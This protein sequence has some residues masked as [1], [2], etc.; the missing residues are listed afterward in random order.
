MHLFLYCYIISF[1]LGIILLKIGD[2]MK[3]IVKN[4]AK[5]FLKTIIINVMC[6]FVVLSFSVLTTA[7]FTHNIGYK[8]VGTT[9]DNQSQVELYTHYTADGEDTKKAEYEAK[10]YTVNELSIRSEVTK[11]GNAVFLIVSQIFCALILIAFIYPNIWHIGTTDSNLVKFKH[12]P[13][14]KLKGFKIGLIAAIPSFLGVV[15][16]IVA[17]LGAFKT[18]PAALYKFLNSSLYS[19]INIITGNCITVGD[20]A[21]WRIILLLALTLIVPLIAGAAYMLGYNNYSV[22]ERLI[23][24]KK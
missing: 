7:L 18:F 2:C 5:L 9:S 10:G 21:W 13:E 14:D 8:A 20:M 19:F 6:F 16:L 23:Y 1:I 22:G 15:F 17:K 3:E 24:R 11:T 4:G 12:K